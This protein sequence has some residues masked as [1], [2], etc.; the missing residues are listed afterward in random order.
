MSAPEFNAPASQWERIDLR[1]L[2]VPARPAR[3]VDA[4]AGLGEGQGLL[5]VTDNEP[6]GLT[7][8]IQASRAH[9]LLVDVTRV[10]EDEWHVGLRPIAPATDAP[11]AESVLRRSAPFAEM[12]DGAIARLATAASMLTVRRGQVVVPENS[13]WPFV[14]VVF[15]GVVAIS[16]GSGTPRNRIFYE[17]FPYEVFGETEFFDQARA[18]GRV[19]AISKVARILRVPREVLH[20]ATRETPDLIASLGRVAA[21]RVRNLMHSLCAQATLP[22][23]ARIATVLL[24]Y[25]MPDDGLAQAVAPL[26]HMTQAQIAAAAGTVKEVAAR[27]IAELED[28]GMLQRE[29]GHI[30]YLDR[31][32]LADLIR[33]YS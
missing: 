30:R 33:E 26:P 18:A 12:P 9:D 20:A 22:I 8:R 7:S 6:R 15:E 10:A 17:V 11:S 31:Q 24:P 4:L 3:V 2:P 13:E 32:K 16:S 29:H 27:A 14:G 23:I 21:Q 19:V 1:G 25:A 28:H 5:V